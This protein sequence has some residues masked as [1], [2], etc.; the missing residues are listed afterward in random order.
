MKIPTDEDEIHKWLEACRGT[1]GNIGGHL[2][3]RL[4]LMANAMTA[5]GSGDFST[6]QYCEEKAAPL[7]KAAEAGDED[8]NCALCLIASRLLAHGKALPPVLATYASTILGEK[9]FSEP[10]RGRGKHSPYDYA[11]RN[12]MIVR[13][14]ETVRDERGVFATRNEAQKDAG[15]VA[16]NKV[17]ACSVVAPLFGMHERAVEEVWSRRKQFLIE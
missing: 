13:L 7:F 3:K 2:V 14:V 5:P 11:T 8:A 4:A 12:L 15:G 9:G 1:L 17:S 10:S 6:A 16:S